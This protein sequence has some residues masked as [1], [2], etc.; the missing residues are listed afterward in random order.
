MRRFTLLAAVL[1]GGCY[2]PEPLYVYSSQPWTPERWDTLDEAGDLLGWELQ[3]IS[4]DY[5]AVTIRWWDGGPCDGREDVAGCAATNQWGCKRSVRS[6]ENGMV[7]AH[8][9]VHAFRFRHND[10]PGDLMHSR[11]GSDT[12]DDAGEFDARVER[13]QHCVFTIH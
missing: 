11:G 1:L 13:F 4:G 2:S 6:V 5:G 9:I 7:L 12:F 8:E 10:M 3:P